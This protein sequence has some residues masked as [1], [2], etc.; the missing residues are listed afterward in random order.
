MA[1]ENIC[2]GGAAL[3]VASYFVSIMQQKI[4]IL[5]VSDLLE[6]NTDLGELYKMTPAIKFLKQSNVK[7]IEVCSFSDAPFNITSA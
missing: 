1:G 3:P 4:P 5:S 2:I 6:A 7:Q